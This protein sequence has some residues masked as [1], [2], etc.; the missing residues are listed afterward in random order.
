MTART[1]YQRQIGEDVTIRTIDS[2]A[3]PANTANVTAK[4]ALLTPGRWDLDADATTID[5]F[6]TS[7]RAASGTPGEPG[8]L[9]R[10][11]DFTL[12]GAAS[13]EAAPGVWQ[14]DWTDDTGG[15]VFTADPA[16]I[17]MKRAASL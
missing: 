1:I 7:F 8:Y 6:V 13:A 9:A 3:D 5:G 10:G 17:R 4:M 11:W 2:E 14:F 16:F 12:P 15:A